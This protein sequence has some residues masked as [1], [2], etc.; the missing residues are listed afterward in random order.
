MIGE[1]AAKSG[2]I[3]KISPEGVQ[4][5]IDLQGGYLNSL[6]APDGTDILFPRQDLDGKDR[7][8]VFFA[9]HLV[10]QFSRVWN[11]MVLLAG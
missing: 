10:L 11:S 8:A 5:S 7:G 9:C 2:I 3:E 1:F 6:A 4:A